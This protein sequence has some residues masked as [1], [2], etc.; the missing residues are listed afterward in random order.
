MTSVTWKKAFELTSKQQIPEA[1]ALLAEE[2][3]KWMHTPENLIRAAR[4][5]E[6]KNYSFCFFFFFPNTNIFLSKKKKVLHKW[7]S[8]TL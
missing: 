1:V 3:S 4:H 6:G 5:Y 2:R 7:S 8:A